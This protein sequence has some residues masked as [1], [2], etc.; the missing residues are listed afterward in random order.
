MKLKF[1][2]IALPFSFERIELDDGQ[3]LI[4][5]AFLFVHIDVRY[6]KE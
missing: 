4:R 2:T 6:T 5:F 1:S 3:G